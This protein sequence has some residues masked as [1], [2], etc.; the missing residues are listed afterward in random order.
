[1]DVNN[2]DNIPDHFDS[3]EEAGEFWDT[4]SAA[5]YW[6]E[7][8]EIDME[9]DLQESVFLLP[10]DQQI[11]KKIKL[12]AETEH[13]SIEEIIQHVLEREFA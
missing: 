1:M 10:I 12:K 13:R 7:M 3:L 5:D 11:Y 2:K 8:E 6:D 9:F 4:H